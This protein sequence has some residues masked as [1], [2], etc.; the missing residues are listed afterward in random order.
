MR[1]SRRNEPLEPE[2]DDERPVRQPRPAQRRAQPLWRR[3]S[4]PARIAIALGTLLFMVVVAGIVTRIVLLDYRERHRHENQEA[5][6]APADP[7]IVA[8]KVHVDVI[9]AEIFEN[10]SLFL[11]VVVSTDDDRKLVN[12]TGW[13]RFGIGAAKMSDD[14]GNK[15][16]QK[17][18][19]P[20]VDVL[21]EKQWNNMPKAKLY[22]FGPG[23]VT[24]EQPRVEVLVFPKPPKA[25]QYVDLE[26]GGKP[27]GETKPVKKRVPASLWQQ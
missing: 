8:D 4:I 13:R 12:F 9:A 11:F 25:I 24:S 10:D 21:L 5:S 22:R 14:A 26:L 17:S 23:P 2:W 16:T 1:P 15:Y 7:P 27:I 20:I 18:F 3:L 6:S 19:D